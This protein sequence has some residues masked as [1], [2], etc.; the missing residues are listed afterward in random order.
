M[1]GPHLNPD[2][3]IQIPETKT[4]LKEKKRKETKSCVLNTSIQTVAGQNLWNDGEVDAALDVS[5]GGA[6]KVNQQFQ[7]PS[8]VGNE[9][10][11]AT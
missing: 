9:L 7:F 2:Y 5:E 11:S 4:C 6:V 8:F 1:I 10:N 3:L